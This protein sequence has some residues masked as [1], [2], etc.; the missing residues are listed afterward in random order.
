MYFGCVIV[1]ITPTNIPEVLILEPQMFGDERGLF[2]ESFNQQTFS[3]KT[4]L[5]YQF[6][7]DNHSRSIQNVLRGLH[8]QV[9]QTQGKLVR[10]IIGEIYDV[11]IDIRRRSATFGQWV[12]IYLS[13]DNKKQLWVPPGFAHGYYVLSK[14]A[15]VL[16][17][18]TDYYAPKHERCIL[19]NDLS[20]AIDWPLIRDSPL[21]SEKD[22]QASIFSSAEVF[23]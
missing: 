19:W 17:K 20:L 2:W 16:Y 13:A 7:Q 23:E 14:S 12:G 22:R 4:G 10:V 5:A 15:D 3:D 9:K 1:N 11:A 8:Y 18:T 21:L 6:V